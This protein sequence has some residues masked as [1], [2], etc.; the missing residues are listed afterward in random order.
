MHRS[1]SVA[2][3]PPRI[4]R[5]RGYA[6]IRSAAFGI[7]ACYAVWV[8]AVPGNAAPK[9]SVAPPLPAAP[10]RPFYVEVAVGPF[11]GLDRLVRGLEA[12][13]ELGLLPRS[14][15]GLGAGTRL[16]AAYDTALGALAGRVECR[17]RLG[18]DLALV[19]G[20]EFP[21]GT[22]ARAEATSGAQILLKPVE[23]LSRFGLE[24]ALFAREPRHPGEPRLTLAAEFS[25]TAY[26]PLGLVGGTAERRALAEARA[27]QG[28]FEAGF[29]LVLGLRA[30]WGAGSA[31][32]S[33]P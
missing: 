8:G 2:A 3:S 26:R 4:G 20:A 9:A 29:R 30:A 13:L 21:A 18:A 33:P 31:R 17:A 25:Y 24:A 1:T 14:S 11:L 16:G 7:A 27:A 32:R 10:S 22:L 5:R 15:G 6:A 12:H 28:A 19:V 23:P